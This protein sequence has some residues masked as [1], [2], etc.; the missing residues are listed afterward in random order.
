MERRG[1]TDKTAIPLPGRVVMEP[2]RATAAEDWM[3]GT[4]TT[5]SSTSSS[6][7]LPVMCWWICPVALAAAAATVDTAARVDERR[8]GRELSFRG[9]VLFCIQVSPVS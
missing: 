7:T 9:G 8:V 2:M 1:E 6:Y 5:C 3:A 4:A